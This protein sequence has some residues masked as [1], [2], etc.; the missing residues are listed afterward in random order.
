MTTI[1]RNLV[2][3]A[4]MLMALS[5]VAQQL[6][7]FSSMS[8]DGW[9]YNGGTALSMSAIAS[10][11]ITLYVT[12]RGVPL[13]LTSPDF[14][15]QGIDSIAAK[16]LWCTQYFNVSGFDLSKTAVT[17]AIDDLNGQP[18]DSVTCVPVKTGVS[19]QTLRLS[20]AV[21]AGLAAGRLRFVSWQ[22]TVDCCGAIKSAEL[23]P[24]SATP[25][26]VLIGDV[27][28]SGDVSIAD[29][30][31]LIDYLLGGDSVSVNVQAADV[32]RDGFIAIGDVTTLID[33]LL[34][35]N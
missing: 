1:K 6:P 20:L 15:C 19:N 35:G 26:E 4:A 17:M 21:P 8:Y 9:S 22:A 10:G 32:D 25:H 5:A 12:S 16:V 34:S 27:D 31:T 18:I 11:K 24:V 3:L 2:M 14:S 7:Q 33:R 23:T 13:T 30:T 29:V 28:G